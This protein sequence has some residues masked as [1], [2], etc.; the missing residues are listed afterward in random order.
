M[1]EICRLSKNFCENSGRTVPIDKDIELALRYLNV[2]EDGLVNEIAKL[3]DPA[4]QV[5]TLQ[6]KNCLNKLKLSF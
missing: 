3:M 2:D 1:N 4:H 5:P 6:G